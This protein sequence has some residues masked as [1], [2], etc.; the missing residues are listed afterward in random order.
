MTSRT[1]KPGNGT[2][3]LS[4]LGRKTRL[5]AKRLVCRMLDHDWNDPVRITHGLGE[6]V[7]EVTCRRCPAF[8][9]GDWY[10]IEDAG[11]WQHN[12][13]GADGQGRNL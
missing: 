5:S 10:E 3:R 13:S 7:Y 8:L 1:S 11:A 2:S 12:R 4:E 9:F 6:P